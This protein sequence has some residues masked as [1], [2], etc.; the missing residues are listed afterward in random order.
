MGRGSSRLQ[1]QAVQQSLDFAC[2]LSSVK[3]GIRS[4]V[5]WGVVVAAKVL[6]IIVT[7]AVIKAA[8]TCAGCC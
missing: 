8:A 1:S 3:A 6:A 7:M 2:A 4:A 5:P